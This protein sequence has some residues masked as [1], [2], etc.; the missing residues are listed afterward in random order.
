[1]TGIIPVLLAGGSGTR[2]WPLSRKSYPKQFSNL[3][4][5][6]SLFQQSALRLTSSEKITFAPHMT[7]TNSEFRFIVG[8]QLHSVGL[9]PGP[10]LIEPEG[11]N[12]APAILAASQY[13]FAR[14]PEA[15]LLVAP[16]D[17]VIPDIEAFH[18]ELQRGLD[19]VCE[20]K[21]VT[22]GIAPTRPE[23]GYGYLELA[24]ASKSEAVDLLR[25]VEKPDAPRAGHDRGFHAACGGLA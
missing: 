17:H 4:G 11:K 14:D 10:I 23:T 3:I 21:I 19:A 2:L 25:F 5:G 9:E 18:E 13:A 24:R 6:R 7:M 12:T 1:M 8:E 15:V 20:G 22:F 16:S